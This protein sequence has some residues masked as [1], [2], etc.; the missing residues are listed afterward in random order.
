MP[1]ESLSRAY[2]LTQA[3]HSAVAEGDWPRAAELAEVRSPLLMSLTAVQSPEALAM[4]RAI[5]GL[6]AGIER[7]AH[8]GR[9]A[10]ASRQNDAMKRIAAA[11]LYQTTGLL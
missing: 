2:E 8:D 5:Q 7:T 10:M 3:I 6:D 4:I 11:N 1:I 9:E